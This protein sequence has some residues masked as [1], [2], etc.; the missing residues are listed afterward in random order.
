MP[1][2]GETE[3]VVVDAPPGFQAYVVVNVPVLLAVKTV[4]FPL[5][6]AAPLELVM[7]GLGVGLINIDT[8]LV[9]IA[10][11]HLSCAVNVNVTKPVSDEPGV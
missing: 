2:G 4:L 7:V 9:T 3:S 11:A 10:N 5:Q 6:I 1:V 8:V